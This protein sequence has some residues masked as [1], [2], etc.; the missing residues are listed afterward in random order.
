MIRMP[1]PAASSSNAPAGSAGDHTTRD[2]Q[3]G[4]LPWLAIA[5]MVAIYLAAVPFSL[6]HIDLARDVGIALDIV[7]GIAY[8]LQG[9]VLAPMLA[10]D[11][12][13]GPA[14]YYLL[15]VPIALTRS[16]L[17]TVLTVGLLAAAKF[18][19]A[20]AVGT[21]LLDWRFGL[22]WA[23]MLLLP[24]WITFEPLLVLHQSLI[25][26]CTLA[27]LWCC[28]RYEQDGRG[29][30]LV[31]AAFLLALAPHAHPSMYGLVVVAVVVLL[32]RWLIAG[33]PA[34]VGFVAA[35]AFIVPFAPYLVDQARH[36]FPAI[37]AAG[38]YF[39]STG[40]P[41]SLRNLPALLR[42]I[43]WTGPETVLHDFADA[44]VS[45][46]MVVAFAYAATYAV[47][48]AGLTG[49][50][51]QGA[52]R[53]LIVASIGL[54]LALAA[55]V[56]LVRATTPYYMTYVVSVP[57]CGLVALGL[58]ASAD[59]PPLSRLVPPIAAVVAVLSLAAT[60]ASASALSTG[61]YRFAFMP[62][63]DVQASPSRGAEVPFMPA[64]AMA[65]GG[66]VLCA[67]REVVVHG[68]YA[69]HLTHDYAIEAR[70]GCSGRPS[71]QLGGALPRDAVHLAGIA[72]PI[73]HAL[74]AKAADRIGPLVLVP[75]AQVLAPAQGMRVADHR[76]YPPVAPELRTAEHSAV[77][78]TARAD[79]AVLV[80]NLNFAFGGDPQV[81]ATVDGR[82]VEP[83][84][85][86][87]LTVSFLCRDCDAA[88]PHQWLLDVRA[89]SPQRIDIVTVIAGP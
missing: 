63:F 1:V 10:R 3:P 67:Q 31:A 7:D 6:T 29:I 32:R 82:T 22:I 72:E 37:A 33:H 70:L 45:A 30:H 42:G 5:A 66:R 15:A 55:S 69:V 80:T 17:A 58:R 53:R 51:L 34:G 44:G 87:G 9:P 89:P 56:V 76:S 83:G 71:I 60:A 73:A 41:G 49:W 62:L 36:G 2:P 57:L 64:Y 78:F 20:Y 75:L 40:G 39:A 52:H 68:A 21:R 18:P 13:L 46:S 35:A 50:L 16:W 25:S 43:V 24:G 28:I 38:T 61:R 86:D 23:L 14:W 65:K 11:F 88:A 84:P 54:V 59:L 79:E 8:P 19:L 47:A 26:T 12:H 27:L 74:R 4:A 77:E 48:I 81:T 85:R